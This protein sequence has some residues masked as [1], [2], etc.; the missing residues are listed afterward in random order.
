M[1]AGVTP[2]CRENAPQLLPP[3]GNL[4][5]LDPARQW[6]LIQ[7]LR[8]DAPEKH[9]PEFNGWIQLWAQLCSDELLGALKAFL[10][11]QFPRS[12][13]HDRDDVIGEVLLV[14]YRNLLWRYDP[15]KAGESGL[16][17][18]LRTVAKRK[19][20]DRIRSG[21]RAPSLEELFV[22]AKDESAAERQNEAR[23]TL[24]SIKAR[25]N[26]QEK[27]VLEG[28]LD[29]KTLREIAADLGGHVSASQVDHIWQRVKKSA[30]QIGD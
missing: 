17:N 5:T 13:S 4:M 8:C 26:D 6:D 7:R 10:A 22:L 19:M 29:S 23:E 12:S 25:L 30:I 3:R 20:L 15:E 18:Y 14:L 21:G 11:G 24:D 27:I 28:K 9:T 16:L 1:V 2:R